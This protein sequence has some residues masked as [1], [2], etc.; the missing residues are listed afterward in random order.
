MKEIEELI[1]KSSKYG[2]LIVQRRFKSKKNTVCYVLINNKAC[3]IKWYAP[4]FRK[5]MEKEFKV[6]S[7]GCQHISMPMVF[8]KDTDN[9]VL[10]LNY[11]SGE[12]LCDVLHNEQT[13]SEDKKQLMTLLAEWYARFHLFFKTEDNYRI[14][15]DSILR[16][17]I[18]SDCIWGVDFEESRLGDRKEDIAGIAASLLT[19]DPMFTKEKFLLC[20]HYISEY[21]KAFGTKV[22]QISTDISYVLLQKIQYRPDDE[23][24]IRSFVEQIRKNGLYF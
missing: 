17:F 6:L 14:H 8:Q 3:V 10:L 22:H 19:T 24:I 16:N 7:E 5:N 15:G 1:K 11:I 23:Q 2:K 18:V 13:R 12:N 21:E 20:R 4:A 9:N